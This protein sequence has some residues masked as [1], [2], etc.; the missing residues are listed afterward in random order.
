MKAKFDFIPGYCPNCGMKIFTPGK[1]T[2][3]AIDEYYTGLEF[4]CPCG[5]VVVYDKPVK[6]LI[7][8]IIPEC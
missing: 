1:Y 2:K 5:C 6:K 3:M 4:A 8:E 7:L